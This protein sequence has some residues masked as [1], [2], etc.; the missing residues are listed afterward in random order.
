M[1]GRDLQEVLDGAPFTALN[2]SELDITDLSAVKT[3]VSGHEV[4]I[5]CAAFTKVDDAESRE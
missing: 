1:L 3:A 5:N 2:R 4:V